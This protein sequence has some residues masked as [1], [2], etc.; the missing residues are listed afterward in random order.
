LGKAYDF[1]FDISTS[2]KIVCSELVY[3]S[4]SY[5]DWPTEKTMGRYT[6][7]PDHIALKAKNK[8]LSIIE[9]YLNGQRVSSD[10]VSKQFSRL[11]SQEH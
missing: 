9:L 3:I 5:I 6:I 7:S 4:Y 8:Q 11:L 10:K 1:N 2:D